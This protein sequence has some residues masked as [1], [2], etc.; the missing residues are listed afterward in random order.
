VAAIDEAD[1]RELAG[2]K[3]ERAPV[4]SC[5]LNVDG[6]RFV[7]HQDYEHELDLLMR[8]A[9]AKANGD[10]SVAED[11][12]RIEDFVRSGFDRSHVRGV[13]VFSCS[14]EHLWK[15]FELPVPVRNQLVVNHSAYVRPL[16]V[17]VEDFEPFGVVLA[18]RQRGR[19]FVFELGELVEHE[20][21]FEQLPRG[22][23]DDQSI[24][25]ERVQSHVAAHAHQHVRHLAEW[26]F[27]V[28]Q[29]HPFE[30]LLVGAPEEITGE[31]ERALH[32]YLQERL[33]GRIS[34]PV[35]ASADD[36]RA[37]ALEAA[38]A[39]E[40]R[41]EAEAVARL[42]DAV[43][44]RRRGVAGV[45]ATLRALVERRVDTLLVSDGF[46]EPGWR[47][48]RCGHLAH[49]GPACPVCDTDM[50]RTDDVVEEAVEEALNQSC[51]VIT[52]TGNADLDVLGRIGA[53][54]RF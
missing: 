52:C 39:V 36:V 44:A 23:D 37:V 4:T 49:V 10:R 47:C 12:A 19:M 14:A 2:L 43:G 41:K 33:A 46:S 51:R 50:Y 6:R 27:H 32:P 28:F 13:A 15:V 34:I 7:R 20:E 11:L 30:H 45:D 54:L 21:L 42:R 35:H 26:A 31:I 53:L 22:D 24:L 29:K 8:D 38:A 17:V 3:G 48:T 16:E 1:I 5:Y 18:D 25:R 9:R 40:R